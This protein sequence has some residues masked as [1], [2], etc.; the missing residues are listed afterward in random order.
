MP[1][2]KM[3]R[4]WRYWRCYWWMQVV[5]TWQY[6]HT[7]DF[8]MLLKLANSVRH[9]ISAAIS[10]HISRHLCKMPARSA[11]VWVRIGAGFTASSGQ[12]PSEQLVQRVHCVVI[13]SLSLANSRTIGTIQPNRVTKQ[14]RAPLAHSKQE[15]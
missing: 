1:H 14:G 11:D 9:S 4:Y 10:R 6:C 13:L 2:T 12:L 15:A 7:G 3:L 8:V 5:A